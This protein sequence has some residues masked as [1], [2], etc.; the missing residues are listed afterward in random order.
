MPLHRGKHN[1]LRGDAPTQRF[2]NRPTDTRPCVRIPILLNMDT[3]VTHVDDVLFPLPTTADT[4]TSVGIRTLTFP[5][6]PFKIH[7]TIVGRYVPMPLLYKISSSRRLF[8]RSICD[9][10][11]M[12][13]APRLLP[14]RFR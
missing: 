10:L 2:A 3:V 4:H 6:S 11:C 9:T 7:H 5:R 1:G 12:P 14:A 13:F 8:L